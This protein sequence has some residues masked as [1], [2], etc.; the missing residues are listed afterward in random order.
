[1]FYEIRFPEEISMRS[2]TSIEFS[3]DV[4]VYKNGREQRVSNRQP[5]MVYDVTIDIRTKKEIDLL[6]D[7]FRL[8]K[9]RYI[10]FRYKDWLDFSV[11]K[12]VIFKSDG[13]TKNF[14]L[15]K[16][17]ISLL[18]GKS[19]LREIIKPVE[20]TVKLFINDSELNS[21]EID[22]S[23]GKITLPAAPAENSLLKAT[24]EFDVPARFDTDTLEIGMHDAQ[25]G[26]I[27]N[28]RIVE[29]NDL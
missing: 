20:G 6:M 9:G 28:I 21:F 13:I 29:I 17:Y 22:Y 19:R 26:E 16:T 12:Q 1:M 23:L 5:K 14:Q 3:T 8:V 18:D 2:K 11:E 10:G 15:T 24:F 7:F 27:K 4:I 25:S